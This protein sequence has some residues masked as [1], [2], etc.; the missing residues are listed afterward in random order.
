MTPSQRVPSP[1]PG[2]VISCSKPFGTI[3]PKGIS[4]AGY[5]HDHEGLMA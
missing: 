2:S 3:S 1:V 4:A 5:I